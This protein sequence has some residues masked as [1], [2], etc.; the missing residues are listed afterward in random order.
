MALLGRPYLLAIE[1]EALSCDGHTVEISSERRNA[2]DIGMPIRR[3]VAGERSGVVATVA[4]AFAQDPG[5][6]FILG[7]EYERLAAHFVAAMFDVRVAAQNVWVTDDLAAVAMWDSPHQSDAGAAYAQSVWTRYRAIAG[8]DAVA[9]LAGYHHAVA[10]V[11]PVPPYWYLGVLATHPR[12]Q[13][14][15]LAT[16]VLAPTLDEADRLGVACCLETST[17]DNRRFYERRG[18]TQATEIDLPGGPPTWWLRRPAPPPA[19]T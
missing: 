7:E 4:A 9:R 19:P 14:E 13:R 11:S 2:S 15:G 8:E 3:A 10:A 17:A 1:T 5:W 16:A 6:A 18:F 12:R